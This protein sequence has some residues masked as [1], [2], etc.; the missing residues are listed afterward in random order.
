MD[1]RLRG[2]KAGPGRAIAE[3]IEAAVRLSALGHEPATIL[4]FHPVTLNPFQPQ[5]YRRAW[6]NGLGPVPLHRIEELDELAPLPELGIRTVLHLHWTHGVLARAADEPAARAAVGKFLERLDRFRAAGGKL[7]WTVHNVL[8]H[9][10]RFA[11][12]EAQLQQAVV[13]RADVV[14]IMAR[15]TVEAVSQWFT[16]P[17][18]TVLHVPLPS[19]RGVYQDIVSGSEARHSLG[20]AADEVVYGLFGAIKPYKGLAVLLDAFEAVADEGVRPRRLLVAGAP[21]DAPATEAFLARARD[22]PA[23]TLHARRIG[24]NEMQLFLRA[25]D[26]A[27]LPYEDVLNSSVLFLVLTFGLPVVAPS[28]GGIAEEIEP[29]FGRTFAQGDPGSLAA[30]LLATDE[31]IAPRAH[32]ATAAAALDV[33][34]RHD[35][36]V[37]GDAFAQGILHGIFGDRVL[38]YGGS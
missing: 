36:D 33:A 1:G 20:I 19:Y 30:A 31:L 21:D 3:A 35:P 6:D 10:A 14:H 38:P 28:E 24:D 32:S 17:S 29:T 5:L 15:D 9:D 25:T 16:I 23:V 11:A 4:A 18:T 2:T 37:I 13:D 34:A 26:V 22:H 7:C 8:P 27:V 12:I